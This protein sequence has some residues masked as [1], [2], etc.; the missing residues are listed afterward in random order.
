[1]SIITILVAILVVGLIVY[2]ISILPIP[3]VFKQ[4]AYIL[5]VILLILW[6]V[7]ALPLR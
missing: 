2:L 6:L 1:M 5:A 7:G 4:V 3:P